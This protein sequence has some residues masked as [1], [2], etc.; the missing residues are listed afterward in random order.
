MKDIFTNEINQL[1]LSVNFIEKKFEK[2]YFILDNVKN[3][4][5]N[6]IL[7][8]NLYYF[9]LI[10]EKIKENLE[11]I[12]IMKKILK[13]KKLKKKVRSTLKKNAKMKGMVTIILLKEVVNMMKKFEMDKYDF[14]VQNVV[15]DERQILISNVPAKYKDKVLEEF[16][17]IDF[18]FFYFLENEHLLEEFGWFKKAG[19][20]F[21][22]G[23]KTVGRGAVKV[24]TAVGRGVVKVG[25]TIGKGAS[26][27]WSWAKK[28]AG[29]ILNSIKA[30]YNKIK[31]F[32]TRIIKNISN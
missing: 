14:E 10:I 22:K 17:M 32:A 24:G 29:K 1:L 30:A 9:D 7:F 12:Q 31:N 28:Q 16:G 2:N 8:R 5:E 27:A 21:V 23:V 18:N 15:F 26:S 25:T 19:K 13:N 3:D 20:S 4:Q 6:I 11:E